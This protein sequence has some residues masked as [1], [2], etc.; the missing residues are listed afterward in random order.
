MHSFNVLA[1]WTQRVTS[2][3]ED[4][5]PPG[6]LVRDIALLTLVAHHTDVGAAWLADRIGLS[7]SGTVRI[8]D[9]LVAAGLL[10]RSGRQGHHVFVA[11][12]RE[13]R[14]VLAAW[15]RQRDLAFEQLVG[16]L[17]PRDRDELVRL[18]AAVLEG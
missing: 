4:A 9:R 16:H 1:A 10:S 7:Q 8:I 17:A 6:V 11:V 15:Q 12:T 2:A 14:E 18:M 3:V 13:G 5:L